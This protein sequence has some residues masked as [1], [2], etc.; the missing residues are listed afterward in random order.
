MSE[1]TQE[2]PVSKVAMSELDYYK[3][4][5]A[6]DRVGRIDAEMKAAQATFALLQTQ[7]RDAQADV[8]LVLKKYGV[9]SGKIEVSIAPPAPAPAP[10]A[11]VPETAPVNGA[12]TP[13][14][15]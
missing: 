9:T 15:E 12:G 10:L 4:N 7:H 13:A 3:F 14:A 2:A 11:L 5:A 6:Q 1:V 8:V